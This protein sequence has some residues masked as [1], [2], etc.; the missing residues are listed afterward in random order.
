MAYRNLQSLARPAGA[1]VLSVFSVAAQCQSAPAP[2]S[3]ARSDFR[4]ALQ[5]LADYSPDPCGPPYG[6]E[7]DWHT[8]HIE[9]SAFE[10]AA[11][12][13][14]EKLN[15][16]P[17]NPGSPLDRATEAIKSLEE[18]SAEVN[19]AWP[20]EKRFHFQILDLP[21]ALVVKLTLR[22]HE[23]FFVFGIPQKDA[24][25]PNRFWQNVGSDDRL[26]EQDMLHS[27]LSLHPLHRGPSGNT[28]FLA[29]F[30][31]S[32]CAGSLGVAYDA[33]EWDPKGSGDL[34]Q[35]I[36]QAGSFGLDDKVPGFPQIGTLQTQGSL[37]SLPYCWFSRIDTWD[38]P[39]L[40]A[41]DTY[42]ISGDAVS[43]RARAYNRPDLVPIAKAVEYAEQRD[44]PAVL[45]Y[46][47]SSEIARKL[48]RDFPP[49]VFADDL[50]LT[51][52]GK[53][54]EHVEFGFD[55]TYRFDVEMLAGRWQIVAFSQE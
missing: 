27:R 25:K 24:G 37:I 7:E 48:V 43:F 15:A 29:H 41:V 42:D 3:D 46:C 23:T 12:I 40:C 45:S 50:R 11:N 52:T 53:G 5:K 9:S 47:S 39:S 1:F 31:Y 28:R 51:H 20:E 13:V 26:F 22:S 2:Q 19:A 10:Q 54:K 6:K 33:R 49:Y 4:Q 16:T 18:T 44:Y 36:K 32:G 30:D 21:P 14:V 55:H 8:S 35:V 17:A 34:K 38:N